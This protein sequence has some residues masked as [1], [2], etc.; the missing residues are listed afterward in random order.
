MSRIITDPFGNFNSL[1]K[2]ISELPYENQINILKKSR[3]MTHHHFGYNP[4]NPESFNR[5][6]RLINSRVDRKISNL[7][8]TLAAIESNGGYVFPS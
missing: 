4:D 2:N 8:R 1:E 5:Y 7:R 3:V 6:L